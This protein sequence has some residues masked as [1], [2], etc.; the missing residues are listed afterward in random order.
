MQHF[1]CILKTTNLKKYGDIFIKTGKIQ[2]RRRLILNLK[3][4]YIYHVRKMKQ[5]CEIKETLTVTPLNMETSET[6]FNLVF[7]MCS[8]S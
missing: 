7:F 4:K 2:K 3:E 5:R 6:T 8:S 1:F